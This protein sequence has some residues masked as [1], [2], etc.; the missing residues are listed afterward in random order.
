MPEG[1]RSGHARFAN[2]RGDRRFLDFIPA[3]LHA[4]VALMPIT[5]LIGM[6]VTHTKALAA[7]GADK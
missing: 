2:A 1:T 7:R 3:R 5:S 6:V 4:W